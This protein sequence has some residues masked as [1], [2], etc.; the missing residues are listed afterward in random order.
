MVGRVRLLCCCVELFFFRFATFFPFKF[1]FLL[2]DFCISYLLL[3]CIEKKSNNNMLRLT[4]LFW[5]S[6]FSTILVQSAFF[7]NPE[8]ENAVIFGKVRPAILN[9]IR[10][11]FMTICPPRSGST[12][13]HSLLNRHASIVAHGEP[14]NAM[15]QVNPTLANDSSWHARRKL[16]DELMFESE[17]RTWHAGRRKNVTAF[18]FKCVYGQ[19][20]MPTVVHPLLD[21]CREHAIH[22]IRLRR[23]N[24]L[25]QLIS[26]QVIRAQ[27]RTQNYVTLFHPK[28]PNELV[29]AQSVV[30]TLNTST[31]LYDLEQQ[32]HQ[33][34]LVDSLFGVEHR[35]RSRSPSSTFRPPINAI[36]IYYEDLVADTEAQLELIQKFL[37][38]A[39]MHLDSNLVKIHAQNTTLEQLITNPQQVRE[40]LRETRFENNLDCL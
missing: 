3:L 34:A 39:P 19:A 26:L 12:W 11:R 27:K 8:A 24:P 7:E 10:V 18:G 38:V 15:P 6:S 35:S 37:G 30:P 14:F 25:R 21:Y 20:L 36:T 9:S 33:N 5:L 31:L 17:T 2:L 4:L 40:I 22:V 13:L 1:R 32:L 23:R 29:E 16:L 28:R